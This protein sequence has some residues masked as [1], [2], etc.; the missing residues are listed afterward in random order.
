MAFK[1]AIERADYGLGGYAKAKIRFEAFEGLARVAIVRSKVEEASATWKH[2]ASGFTVGL[3][4]PVDLRIHGLTEALSN[5]NLAEREALSRADFSS[6]RLARVRLTQGTVQKK[7]D[8][9]RREVN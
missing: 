9:L 7:I 6:R 1:E 2:S 3:R 8:D 5:L 4:P